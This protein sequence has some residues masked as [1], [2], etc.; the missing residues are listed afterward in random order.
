LF[1]S[2]D[3][4]LW[5]ESSRF[6]VTSFVPVLDDGTGVRLNEIPDPPPEED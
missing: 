4:R 6:G 2:P 5:I 1:A 3:R